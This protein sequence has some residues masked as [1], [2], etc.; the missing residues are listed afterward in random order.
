MDDVPAGNDFLGSFKAWF[1]MKN[2]AI[3]DPQPV[4]R[5]FIQEFLGGDLN[6]ENTFQECRLFFS[7]LAPNPVTESQGLPFFGF[8][9]P[10][11]I[12]TVEKNHCRQ[13]NEA[14]GYLRPGDVVE[15]VVFDMY[16]PAEYDQHESIQGL[17]NTHFN[18]NA[19]FVYVDCENQQCNSPVHVK[20][21]IKILEPK[22][23]VVIH[24]DRFLPTPE[25]DIRGITDEA[26]I[27]RRQA[28]PYRKEDRPVQLSHV[29]KLPLVSGTDSVQYS[30]I[31]TV[32]HLGS[33]G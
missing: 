14:P 33:T 21:T 6:Y 28:I 8:M 32:Q 30:L 23:A 1:E 24:I 15:N 4:L 12:T 25:N 17:I 10:S 27:R 3:R 22:D 29:I 7:G 2:S 9:R 11:S 16:L 19:N 31:A 20:T 26:E 5:K 18:A 13:C